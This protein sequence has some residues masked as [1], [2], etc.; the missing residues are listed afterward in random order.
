MKL[1]VQCIPPTKLC[2]LVLIINSL[3]T[4]GLTLTYEYYYV[5]TYTL[6][7]TTFILCHLIFSFAFSHSLSISLLRLVQRVLLVVAVIPTKTTLFFGVSVFL[8]LC[9]SVD[10]CELTLKHAGWLADWMDG[11]EISNS[12]DM[13]IF[14]QLIVIVYVCVFVS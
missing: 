14:F 10:E 5:L 7:L 6:P 4:Y 3:R 13:R 2:I 11:F 12:K 1:K 9:E 8:F